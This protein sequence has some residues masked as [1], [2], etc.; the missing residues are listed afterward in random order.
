[1]IARP[2]RHRPSR[3]P[4]IVVA[5]ALVLAGCGAD[6]PASNGASAPASATS[7]DT[8][9]ASTA[10]GERSGGDVS[11]AAE[12]TGA[13]TAATV[14]AVADSDLGTVLVDGDGA[15]LYVFDN[16]DVDTS[17]CT[18]GCLDTWPP[19]LADAVEAGE[20]VTADLAT[21]TREDGRVQA[22]ANGLPL[23][24]FA[25]DAGPGD[26]QGQGV[27]GVWWVADATGAA[28]TE[29]AGDE[30]TE[31]PYGDPSY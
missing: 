3:R 24:R 30:S 9:T 14:V 6:E 15:T 12:D 23:Y 11:P 21:F 20:G 26:T 10:T 2:V 7:G 25:S 27:G 8:S 19:V 22:T 28:I 17:A 29:A 1:M 4:A 31:A 18:E 5:I 16:D 13:A